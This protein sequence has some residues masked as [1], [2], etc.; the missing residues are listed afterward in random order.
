[1]KD[2]KYPILL[3]NIGFNN[4]LSICPDEIIFH[5]DCNLYIVRNLIYKQIIENAHKVDITDLYKIDDNNFIS[6][7]WDGLIKIWSRKNKEKEDDKDIFIEKEKIQ[8]TFNEWIKELIISSKGDIFCSS[9]NADIN[10]WKNEGIKHQLVTT[11]NLPNF[12]IILSML[13]FENENLLVVS[14]NNDTQFYNIINFELIK[15]INSGCCTSHSMVKI[16]QTC[17]INEHLEIISSISKKKVNQIEIEDDEFYC[18]QICVNQKLGKIFILGDNKNIKI[19]SSNDFSFIYEIK[20]S[21][22][23]LNNENEE[24]EEYCFFSVDDNMILT[25]LNANIILLININFIKN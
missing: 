8:N 22:I 6:T 7:S 5:D 23:L 11:I 20:L 17:F 21:D 14:G 19:F 18:E 2:E 24:D 4:F 16:N 15:K 13:L 1:M 12:D 3:K 25:L 9:D 10:Y